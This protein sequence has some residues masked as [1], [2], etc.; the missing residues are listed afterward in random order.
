MI[1][2]HV[3][4]FYNIAG[5]AAGTGDPAAPPLVLGHSLGASAG[6]W[7]PQTAGLSTQTRVVTYD[8]R[9]HGRS[10]APPGP[11]S[12]ADLGRDLVRL[13]DDLGLV[14]V[15]L[16]G[17]SLGAMIA[18]WVA[19][20]APDRV[21]RLVLCA[22]SA[23]LGPPEA[24]ASRAETVLASGTAVVAGPVIERWFTPAFAGRYADAVDAA[25]QVFV[26]TS[27]QGYAGCCR[28][29]ETMDLT[30]AL[31]SIRARTLVIAGSADLATPPAHAEVL[32][33]SI[34]DARLELVHAAHLL[35]IEQP[36]V[37]T[38][39]IRGHLARTAAP[40]GGSRR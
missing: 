40:T 8:I 30:P 34:P 35:N 16:G 22:T 7:A 28:A 26:A 31:P 17:L 20:N 10:P 38:R 27:A 39:L 24:W 32:A 21:D 37:V 15:D 4:L 12:I 2:Q 13:L 18:T 36:D 5:P 25:R 11:Y 3:G 33:R 14:K 23:R 9:G 1:A 6:M 29:I 19:A